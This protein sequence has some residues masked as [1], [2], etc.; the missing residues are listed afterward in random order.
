MEAE[1]SD[2][3]L[4]IQCDVGR[5]SKALIQSRN[6]ARGVGIGQLGGSVTGKP[7]ADQRAIAVLAYRPKLE[8]PLQAESDHRRVGFQ[9]LRGV[10][11]R[12]VGMLAGSARGE[13]RKRMRASRCGARWRLSL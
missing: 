11:Q 1:L 3:A 4:G 9:H 5:L 8:R 12:V 7:R 6:G 10:R 13:Q 2:L